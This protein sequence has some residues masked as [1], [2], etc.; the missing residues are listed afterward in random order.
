MMFNVYTIKDTVSE[1]F[2]PPF[3]AVNDAVAARQYRQA[4]S[5]ADPVVRPDYELYRI[6]TFDSQDASIVPS[7]VNIFVKTEMEILNE[8]K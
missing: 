7:E 6:G 4:L 2:A 1:E 8:S 3:V 5:S